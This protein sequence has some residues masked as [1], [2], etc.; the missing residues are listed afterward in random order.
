MPE[1]IQGQDNLTRSDYSISGR[2]VEMEEE[3]VRK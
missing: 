1:M 2:G 3:R